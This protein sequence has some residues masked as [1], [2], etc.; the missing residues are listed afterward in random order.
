MRAVKRPSGSHLRPRI[1]LD[2][3]VVDGIYQG[4]RTHCL[5]LFSRVIAT[6]P[7]C[8]FVIMAANPQNL[9]G[10]STSFA[11]SN[12]ELVAMP[13]AIPATRLLW[14]LPRLVKQHC[15]DLLHTQYIGPPFS[16]C[17]TAVTVHDIL[18]ESHPEYFARFFTLRSRILVRNS[19]RNS[20]KVFTVSEFS[21]KEIVE[22]FLTKTDKIHTILNGVDRVRFYPGKDG[23]EHL[24]DF[25]LIS[26][27]YFLSVGRLE[28]R[29]NHVNLLRAW[30]KLSRPRPRLVIVGQ[31]HFGYNEALNLISTLQLQRDVVVLDRVADDVLPAIFRHAKAFVYCSFAEGFGMPVLEAMASGVPVISSRTTALSEICEGAALLVQ[32]HDVNEISAAIARLDQTA[33]IREDLIRR[34]MTRILAFSWDNSAA[35]VRNAYLAHFGLV[36]PG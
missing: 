23:Q 16:P 36:G 15:I 9:A 12:V 32:P 21:R 20:V 31:R 26:G 19:V 35:I 8:D 1:G 5:E 4:S 18:F 14:Q 27:Q 13:H 34:G 6:T 25:G 17:A 24:D 33:G 22:R 7:E 3:H 29:K 28:P 11:S 30:A 2:L 10:F